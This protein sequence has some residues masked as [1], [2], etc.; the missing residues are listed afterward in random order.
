MEYTIQA[1]AKL[2]GVSSRTLRYYHEIGLL[3]PSR[4]SHGGYRFYGPEE[5]ELLQQIL[6]YRALGVE[7]LKI[8]ALLT[9]GGFDR[10]AAMEEH[11]GALL[12]RREQLDLLILNA[13]KTLDSY[14]GGGHMQDAERFCGFGEKLAVENEREYGPEIRKKYGDEPVDAAHQR[15]RGMSEEQHRESVA[16]EEEMGALLARA[17]EEGDPAGEDAQRACALH[18]RWL[19]IFY[20]AYTREYH[21]G[22]GALYVEDERFFAHYERYGKNCAPFFQKAIEHYCQ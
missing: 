21:R 16:L 3:L 6:F 8:K 19:R 9:Q 5:V 2:A 7:L 13:Q 1:L 18:E 17:L 20:P 14:Q 11:L 12:R 15:L 4:T 10:R 22:L